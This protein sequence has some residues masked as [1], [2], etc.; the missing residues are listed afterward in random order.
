MILNMKIVS[1]NGYIEGYYG[2]LLSWEHRN[3]I[4]LQLNKL[5]FNHYF[6]C[7]KED[8]CQRFDWRK[9]HSNTW[10]KISKFLQNGRKIWNKYNYGCLTGNRF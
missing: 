10:L 1:T 4:L 6:Y 9:N 2:N 8:V 3:R 5:H 7:P